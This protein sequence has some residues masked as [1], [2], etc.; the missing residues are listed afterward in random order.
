MIFDITC[1]DKN[2]NPIE[3]LTQWDSNQ[4]IY[5][6]DMELGQ[7]PVLHFCNIQS[8]EAYAVDAVLMNDGTV[9]AQIPNILLQEALRILVYV[10]EY[11]F[12]EMNGKNL[13]LGKIEVRK[14]TKPNDYKFEEDITPV[15]I[16]AL[17]RQVRNIMLVT[18]P[19]IQK[20]ISSLVDVD[21]TLTNRVND[22]NTRLG[23]TATDLET[24]K[25]TVSTLQNTHSTDIQNLSS[26]IS[27]VSTKCNGAISDLETLSKTHAT[28]KSDLYNEIKELQDSDETTNARIDEVVSDLKDYA[29]AESVYTKEESD[30]R[31][32]LIGN[33]YS[34]DECDTNFAS[35]SSEH[36]H[37]NLDVL[38]E[39]TAERIEQWDIASAGNVVTDETLSV[40]GAAADAAIVGENIFYA[41][42]KHTSTDSSV[43]YT[44]D[45]TVSVGD[46]IK[47]GIKSTTVIYTLSSGYSIN[48][49]EE[50]DDEIIEDIGSMT[51]GTYEPDLSGSIR[52]ESIEITSDYTTYQIE[53]AEIVFV[54][55]G[56]TTPSKNIQD[57]KDELEVLR[58][59]IVSLS[60]QIEALS[61]T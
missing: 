27:D 4:I 26:T 19:D 8:D 28:D 32:A 7:A 37:E 55:G 3:Y 15:N 43:T 23:T 29:L 22:I 58:A 5:I 49:V 12:N 51:T 33:V 24:L 25:G 6:K 39:I 35:K 9:M 46:V 61:T 17:D 13:H 1:V 38:N 44:L 40:S 47:I 53:N 41:S 48:S 16:V 14:K 10:H 30:A 31:Y 59:T 60:A 56:S 20:N 21:T 54:M 52:W 50:E 34:T 11:Y 2:G 45:D 18:I 42:P 36:I 57:L